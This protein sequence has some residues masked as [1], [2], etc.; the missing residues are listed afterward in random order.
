MLDRFYEHKAKYDCWVILALTAFFIIHIILIIILVFSE[1]ALLA[2]IVVGMLLFYLLL[3]A[4]AL[5]RAYKIHSDKLRIVFD[6]PLVWNIPFTTID[7]V[8]AAHGGMARKNLGPIWCVD[9]WGVNL[10]TSSK[11][12]IEI[13]RVTGWGLIISPTDRGAFLK[14]INEAINSYRS[15]SGLID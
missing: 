4:T 1:I 13:R 6:G 8:L 2:W 14:H 9:Y 7:K 11:S 10:A 3:C 5:P 12:V 15:S